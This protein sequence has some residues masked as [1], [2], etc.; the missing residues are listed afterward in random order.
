MF[1]LLKFEKKNL[2]KFNYLEKINAFGMPFGEMLVT[3]KCI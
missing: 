2:E 3:E 1:K